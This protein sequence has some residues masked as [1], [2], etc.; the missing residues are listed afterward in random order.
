MYA[1]IRVVAYYFDRPF[2]V[3]LPA[4]HAI[5]RYSCRTRRILGKVFNGKFLAKT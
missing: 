3:P 4:V 2:L 5:N 1:N